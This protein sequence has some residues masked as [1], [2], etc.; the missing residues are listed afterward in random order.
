MSAETVLTNA[1]VVTPSDVFLGTVLLRAGRIA[2]IDQG[3]SMLP[4]AQDLEG[5]LLVPGLV[6]VH[7]DN[8]EKHMMP[9]PG[10]RW[11]PRAALLAHDAQVAAAGITTVLDA[12]CVGEVEH[13]DQ[14][15]QMFRDG[16]AELRAL[17]P[18]GLLRAE[19]FLHLRCEISVDGMQAS[20]AHVADD[21]LVRMVS[22]MDHTP[23][24]GQFAD[25]EK[26][27][28]KNA[29]SLGMNEQ[30]A[31]AYVA[32]RWAMR[33]KMR[34][35]NRAAILA[36][37]AGRAVAL[38]S[39]DD[40]TE[41]EVADWAGAGIGISEFPVTEAA[42]RAARTHGMGIVAGAPNIVRGGSH[43]G[44]VRAADLVR[45][46]LVDVFASDYVPAAMLSAAMLAHE[47]LHL[48]LP[49]AISTVTQRPALMVGLTDR[50]AVAAGLRA[51]LVQVHLADGH[52]LVRQVWREGRR[53]A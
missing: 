25:I 3:A 5:D 13:A 16:V 28:R 35:P 1:R 27:K 44:N 45:E 43:S 22:L 26:Y 51:D 20:F 50:G 39:H 18:R 31:E 41:E 12:L 47:T 15:D 6:D 40:R 49:A 48:P 29:R 37:V 32:R 38:A 11:S 4:G 14:R 23:G 24:V 8:L 30:E 9:R 52:P 2:R 34:E 10:V 33:A 36:A 46:G 17:A 53:I 21:P 7:T 19:H 42:A